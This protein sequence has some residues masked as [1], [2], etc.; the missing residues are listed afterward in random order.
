MR[1]S[2]I[3]AGVAS[4]L[5]A[6]AAP[7][8]YAGQA[9]YRIVRYMD[10]YDQPSGF[11]EGSPGLFYGIAGSYTTVGF[12]ITPEG[13]MTILVSYPTGY[14]I[15]SLFMGGYDGR[16]YSAAGAGNNPATVFSVMPVPGSER[17]YPP[18]NNWPTMTQ[19]LPDGQMLAVAVGPGA[20]PWYVAKV[21]LNGTVKTIAQFPSGEYLPVVTYADD[22]NYYG[23]SQTTFATT[24]TGYAFRVTPSGS[25]TKLYD[26]PGGWFNGQFSTPLFQAG[27]GNLY[28]AIP[29]GGA[30]KQGIIYKLTLD[31]EFTPLYT[32]PKTI[33]GGP[34][35]LI[36]ASDGNLYGVTLGS[37]NAGGVGQLFR[38]TK[39]GDYKLLY[40][41]SEPARDGACQCRFIQGSDGTFYGTAQGAGRTGAGAVFALDAG[42]PKPPPRLQEFTPKSGP[43]GTRVR[44]WGQNLLS[45]SV[46]FNGAVRLRSPTAGRIMFGPLSRR[47]PAAGRSR[48]RHPAG[49]ARRG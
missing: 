47:A 6:V 35:A 12:T 3:R 13:S 46:Q 32:F 31:G 22:G 30:N 9:S 37:Y 25:M 39:S 20:T 10:Q 42:L 14:S 41:L 15:F 38:V 44:L 2:Y 33:N 27:D 34:T 5:C 16:F 23:I 1:T 11:T 18:Q 19:T 45:A 40:E 26:F 49:R 28:G 17:V 48:S 36:E 21:D 24:T 8:D 43:A 4:L 29:D 7:L